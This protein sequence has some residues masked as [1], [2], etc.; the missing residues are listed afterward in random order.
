MTIR[1]VFYF[2]AALIISNFSSTVSFSA[3]LQ[4][5]KKLYWFIPDGMR[6]DPVLFNIFEWAEQG[7][8]PNIH[9]MMKNGSY[10]YSMPVF[11]SHTPVNFSTL[12]TG[13]NPATHGVADG[14][15]HIE[16]RPLNR[17]SIGGFSSIAKK[18]PPLWINMEAS[19]K[20]VALLSMPGSTPPELDQGITI[21]GRWGGWGADFHAVNFQSTGDPAE[22]LRQTAASR[23]FFFGPELT[24]QVAA[25]PAAGWGPTPATFSPPRE[26]E[27]KA[28]G[29]SI[30]GYILDSSNNG[31][32]DYDKVLFS[33]DKKSIFASL[34]RDEWSE[35]SPIRLSWKEHI[36]GSHVRIKVIRLGSSKNTGDISLRIRCLFNNLNEYITSPSYVSEEVVDG[37]GP[38][39]DF[40]DNF[41]PQLIYYEEDKRTFLEESD[42]SFAWHRKAAK[43]VLERYRPDVFIHDIYTPNQMLTS[44]WW[45]GYVDPSSARYGDVTQSQRKAL[46]KEVRA[47]Y[48]KIDDI[49]GEYLKVAGDD[50]LVVLS[51]DHG[52]VPLDQWVN[53]NNLFAREGLLAYR[54]NPSTGLS[55]I[56]W[57]H[58]QVVYLKMDNIYIHPEGLSGNWRR[59][60]G[61]KYEALRDRVVGLLHSLET[62][63]GQRP[64]EA[65]V[66]WEDVRAY[67][68]LPE[69]RVGDLVVANRAGFGWNEQVTPDLEIFSVPLKSGYKQAILPEDNKG[70]WTPFVIMGPGVKKNH[71]IS[72]PIHHVDQY[73]TIM[74]LMGMDIP[75]FV[76][77]KAIGT[78]VEH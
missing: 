46:W 34:G 21:R 52:A 39:V 68:N 50:T 71:E 33:L 45:L 77:G 14:P 75:E 7:L 62:D 30:F 28:W 40:A 78:A 26:V 6:A 36:V 64:V 53:L 5:S 13:S 59:A 12:L 11:P 73:P 31:K 48:R 27:M 69:D 41:P 9:F 23:L 49:L 70:M 43:F 38:M 17:V 4:S 42:M 56:D 55:E 66:K 25:T 18:V 16:G 19:K 51:S 60:A 35:W 37:V 22:T 24:S 10:G 44:R 2:I 65:V 61:P 29:T 74:K 32:E 58:S 20:K 47:M 3:D 76:E 72:S 57:E 63:A 54:I 1:Q 67:W 15:M 8:L